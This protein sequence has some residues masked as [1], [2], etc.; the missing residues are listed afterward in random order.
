M[1]KIQKNKSELIAENKH[2]VEL[3]AKQYLNQGLTLEQLIEEGNKGLIYADERY[4]PSKG[5]AF[6]SY[7]VWFVRASILQALSAVSRGESI[8]E[9]FIPKKQNRQNRD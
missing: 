8:P 2:Y 9:T 6:M 4:D 3:V 5:F 1:T 7:A